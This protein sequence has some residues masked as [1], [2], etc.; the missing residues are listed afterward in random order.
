M[1][2]PYDDDVSGNCY[3]VR[4]ML[5]LLG[6]DSEAVPVDFAGREHKSPAFLAL[7]PLGQVPVLA[8]DGVRLRDSQAILA[9]LGRRYG[10]G[11]WLPEDAAGL[12]DWLARVEA[13]PGHAPMIER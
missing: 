9:Y 13:L 1:I 6:L 5:A 12:G 10:A 8:E 4:L 3:K 7:N 2:T 11:D